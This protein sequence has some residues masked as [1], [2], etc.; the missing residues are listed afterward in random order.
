MQGITAKTD[1][2][3]EGLNFLISRYRSH[4]AYM[5]FMTGIL[6]QVQELED[7]IPRPEDFYLINAA[8]W[9]LDAWG[10][11][12]GLPRG[13]LGQISDDDYRVL[14]FGKIA[15]NISHGTE[16]DLFNLLGMLQLTGVYIFDVYP[17]SI[18]VNY[19][20]THLVLD[21]D[22]ILYILQRATHPLKIDVTEYQPGGFGFM[23]NL[24]A[25]G[26]SV[27]KL[28]KSAG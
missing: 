2:V 4:P 20:P 15:E 14:I 19:Q 1:H 7:A 27:G 10:V 25:Q 3:E 28:G 13:P 17:G 22:C 6:N 24:N 11:K 16:P 5:Q 12:V 8:D 9:V 21:C 26:F 18:T 23:G